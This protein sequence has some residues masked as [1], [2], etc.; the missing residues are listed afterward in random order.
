MAKRNFLTRVWAFDANG[1]KVFPY[2]GIRGAKKGLYSVNFTSDT[3]NYEG[4]DEAELVSAIESGR[5]QLRGS[6]RMLPLG[7][8]TSQGNNAFVPR[9]LNGVPIPRK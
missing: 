5:F 4:L 2:T 1:E 7:A 8:D 9:F 3:R 6:I